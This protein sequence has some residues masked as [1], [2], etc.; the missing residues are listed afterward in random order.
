MSDNQI[1]L[2][3]GSSKNTYPAKT[4]KKI[5]SKNKKTVLAEINTSSASSMATYQ[6][7]GL[8]NF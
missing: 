8:G 4:L 3:S 2:Y 1:S 5:M 6:P 7:S